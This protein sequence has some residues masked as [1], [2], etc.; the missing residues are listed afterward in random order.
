M[1]RYRC[2]PAKSFKE[3]LE[4][5]HLVQ[6]QYEQ[7][8]FT[9]V[10]ASRLRFFLRDLLPESKTFVHY[11]LKRIVGS[12]SI[13]YNTRASLPSENTFT[14]EIAKL[15]MKYSSIIEGTKFAVLDDTLEN[16]KTVVALAAQ[17]IGWGYNTGADFMILT[18]NPRHEGV[19]KRRF[20]MDRI[21]F[22]EKC[23]HV[24]SVPGVLVGAPLKE[25]PLRKEGVDINQQLLFR[26]DKIFNGVRVALLITLEPDAV[27]TASIEDLI[28]L[29]RVYPELET[30]FPLFPKLRDGLSISRLKEVRPL[31]GVSLLNAFEDIVSL[32]EIRVREKNIQFHAT[33]R[34]PAMNVVLSDYLL[35]L[36]CLQYLLHCFIETTE[37]NS[38]ISVSIKQAGMQR[39]LGMFILVRE[40]RA[41]RFS[42][43]S[44]KEVTQTRHHD[45][46]LLLKVIKLFSGTQ[47]IFTTD[48][49]ATGRYFAALVPLV[50]S[51]ELSDD[52]GQTL[53]GAFHRIIKE[54]GIESRI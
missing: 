40:E 48:S 11:E 41:G 53:R 20:H 17:F 28:A 13:N 22:T 39:S 36:A 8:G 38:R 12:F 31:I 25:H 30:L 35:R 33:V 21:A 14:N 54:E 23:S 32:L 29:L 4:A 24:D 3:V 15:Q 6:Y 34:A 2:A 27:A 5:W 51:N 16:Q 44:H 7:F 43:S 26:D 1:M 42:H 19:W 45:P 49:D 47:G 37:P 46:A 52:F 18:V 9:A 10:N 50:Q